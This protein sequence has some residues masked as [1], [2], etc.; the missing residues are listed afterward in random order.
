MSSCNWFGYACPKNRN[1]NETK[2]GKNKEWT[3]IVVI[4]DTKLVIIFSGLVY[5]LMPD[6]INYNNNN[7]EICSFLSFDSYWFWSH[8]LKLKKKTLGAI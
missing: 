4:G 1:E 8:F 3:N 2:N 5:E 7:F 6:V